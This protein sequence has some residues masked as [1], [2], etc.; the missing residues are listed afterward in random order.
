MKRFALEKVLREKR[1]AK[2]GCTTKAFWRARAARVLLL[3]A[4]PKNNQNTLTNSRACQT[5]RL[6]GLCSRNLTQM[7]LAAARLR[8]GSVET[9]DHGVS[10][11]TETTPSFCPGKK[12]I[13]EILVSE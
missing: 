3:S 11:P 9:S 7:N 12:Q 13:E 1:I 5:W 4:I 6:T 10:S 2:K 8:T